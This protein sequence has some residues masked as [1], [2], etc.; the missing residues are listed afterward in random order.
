M[1]LDFDPVAEAPEIILQNYLQ[2]A[3][4]TTACLV[5]VVATAFFPAIM[6]SNRRLPSIH[7][8]HSN[9]SL[10]K[11]RCSSFLSATNLPAYTRSEPG[12][13]IFK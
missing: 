5:L 13:E 1:S 2:V 4:E 7:L 6:V 3:R 9:Y 11:P 12:I 10:T 8:P